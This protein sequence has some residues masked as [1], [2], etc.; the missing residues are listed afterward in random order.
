MSLRKIENLLVSL[1]S[2]VI[3]VVLFVTQETLIVKEAGTYKESNFVKSTPLH[4]LGVFSWAASPNAYMNLSVS[5]LTLVSSEIG[6]GGK[7]PKLSICIS[8]LF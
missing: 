5:D 2:P 7:G 8:S 6:S 1:G 4:I 3:V